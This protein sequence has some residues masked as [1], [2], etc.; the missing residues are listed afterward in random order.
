MGFTANSLIVRIDDSRKTSGS[1]T[2][3][4]SFLSP[5]DAHLSAKTHKTHSTVAHGFVRLCGTPMIRLVR[6]ML[7]TSTPTSQLVR[8]I[9]DELGRLSAELRSRAELVSRK[10]KELTRDHSLASSRHTLAADD[11]LLDGEIVAFD[12]NECP[13]F[14]RHCSTTR[15]ESGDWCTTPFDDPVASGRIA[16]SRAADLPP[17]AIIRPHREHRDKS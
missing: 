4:L 8:D 13:S 17:L 12:G 11:A 3:R 15:G 2:T 16:S 5:T 14:H 10:Q 6:A 1:G 7:A 9:R